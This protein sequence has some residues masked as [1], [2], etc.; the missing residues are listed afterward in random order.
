[1]ATPST[2]ST[3]ASSKP[4]YYTILGVKATDG[5]EVIREA[6]HELQ[7]Q[8][9]PDKGGNDQDKASAVAEAW[10]VLS[11]PIS[12][13]WY[14]IEAGITPNTIEQR[15]KLNNLQRRSALNWQ[16][17]NEEEFI[18]KRDEQ[19]HANG[20]III[21]AKYGNT[22]V[23]APLG[24][25]VDVVVPLQYHVTATAASVDDA[26]VVLSAIDWPSNDP[27]SR[28]VGFYEPLVGSG[29]EH[30][31]YIR[32]RYMGVEHEM[33]VGD[34]EPFVI[35]EPSHVIPAVELTR[36]ADEAKHQHDEQLR[37]AAVK[38]TRR[39]ILYTTTVVIVA[40]SILLPS[41]W[42]RLRAAV[43]TSPVTKDV[44]AVAPK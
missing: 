37:V 14:D 28:A 16:L 9:H 7:R 44:V 34:C 13:G 39:T 3:T 12:R 26:G 23:N 22:S 42:R 8:V 29:I 30:E 10:S 36:R 11:Q 17:A 2:S 6:Y 4:N 32:Y 1:M 19:R 43:T 27:K 20:L 35:P 41:L 31:L 33:S 24:S 40:S 15:R 38:R 5:I 21:E 25:F 18:T